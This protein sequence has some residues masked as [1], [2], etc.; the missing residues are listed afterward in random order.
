MRYV[1]LEEAIRLVGVSRTLLEALVEDQL[2]Q[3]RSTLEQER[4]ISTDE[5]DELRVARNLL[6]DLGVNMEGVEIIL[7]MR[8][9]QIEL[10]RLLHEANLL[11]PR[12]FLPGA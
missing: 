7:H 1:R 4:V 10:L 8:R 6:E 2:I 12:G 9:R 3:P 5:A 11:A